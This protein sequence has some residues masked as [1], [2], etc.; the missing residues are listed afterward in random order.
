MECFKLRF[1]SLFHWLGPLSE[2]FAILVDTP[3]GDT[4]LVV[5]ISP[6]IIQEIVFV[7]A[8]AANFEFFSP[9]DS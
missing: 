3:G 4:N 9:G 2:A 7:A 8:S 6:H 5:S 1:F